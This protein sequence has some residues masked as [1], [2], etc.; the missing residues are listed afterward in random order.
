MLSL[1]LRRGLDWQTYQRD[2]EHDLWNDNQRLL[3]DLEA[4]GDLIVDLPVVRLTPQGMLRYDM[5]VAALLPE[6]EPVSGS[7]SK[8]DP[9]EADQ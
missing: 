2:F 5:I 7:P 8:N 6:D 4:N 1:R 3:T 9:Q